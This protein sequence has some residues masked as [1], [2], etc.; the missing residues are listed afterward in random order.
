L[1]A[2][3]RVSNR[4]YT[5]ELDNG[6]FDCILEAH[7]AYYEALKSESNGDSELCTD[8]YPNATFLSSAMMEDE[9]DCF[10]QSPESPTPCSD[11][12]V[13]EF[14]CLINAYNNLLCQGPTAISKL[15]EY[16]N[17]TDHDHSLDECTAKPVNT[18]HCMLTML[19][20][21][22]RNQ[23]EI[24]VDSDKRIHLI[25][26]EYI[27]ERVWGVVAAAGLHSHQLGTQLKDE[28]KAKMI[29]EDKDDSPKQL[30]VCQ[31]SKKELKCEPGMKIE[32]SNVN[33][34]KSNGTLCGHEME[35]KT[36]TGVDKT[37]VLKEWCDRQEKCT[38]DASFQPS[39]EFMEELLTD[40]DPCPEYN[41]YIHIEYQCKAE[42]ERMTTTEDPRP[43]MNEEH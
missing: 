34:G 20:D 2:F 32:V 25:W 4:F 38:V 23:D 36:C 37:H 13:N 11:A 18:L 27:L 39:S 7:P 29:Q 30:I 19:K 41:K 16:H 10:P 5:E 42:H 24:V 33:Y 6:Y 15:A 9:R 35:D 21:A 22:L 1:T 8:N 12:I 26:V 17:F 43:E 3:T 14:N 31:D 28:W 40:D